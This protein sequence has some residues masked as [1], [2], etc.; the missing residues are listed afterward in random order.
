MFAGA[1]SEARSRMTKWH[2]FVSIVIFLMAVI[3]AETGLVERIIILSLPYDQEDLI[4]NFTGLLILLSGVAAILRTRSRRVQV[5][6]GLV[7]FGLAIMSA[8]IET[9]TLLTPRRRQNAV[10]MNYTRILF[11]VCR[12]AVYLALFLPRPH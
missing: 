4:M 3:S 1:N 6:I 5:L 12:V 11:P 7:I 8:E 2:I 9:V 10:I